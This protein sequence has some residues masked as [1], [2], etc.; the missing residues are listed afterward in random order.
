M[1][2][3]LRSLAGLLLFAVTLGLLGLAA[4]QIIWASKE[5]AG[6]GPPQRGGGERSFS[7]QVDRFARGPETP[8]ILSYGTVEAARSLELRALTGGRIVEL[9]ED[10]RDGGTVAEGELLFRIDPARATSALNIAT[11]ALEER[12]AELAEAEDRRDLTEDELDAA[13]QQRDLRAQAL[14]RQD[15]L[16]ARGVGT[17]QAA[18]DAQLSLSAAEQTLVRQ[19]QALAEAEAAIRTA[20]IAVDRAGIDLSDAERA[21]AET[22]VAAPFAGVLSDVTAILGRLVSANEKLGQLIDPTA[23]EVAFRVSNAQFARLLDDGGTLQ[24]LP[25]SVTLELDDIPFTLEGRIDRVGAEV[26]DGQTGRLIFAQIRQ[27]G[28]QILQPGDFLTVEIV[29]PELTDVSRIPADAATSDGRVLVLDDEDR[30]EEITLPILRRIGDELI[31]A[32][33]PEGR[34]YVRERL[35]Q[36]GAGIKVKP[37]TPPGEEGAQAP[38]APQSVVLDEARRARLI[39]FVEANTRMPADMRERILKQLEAEEV[40]VAVV[41]RLESR[42]GG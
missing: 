1:N 35:P 31:V 3:L 10:F 39:A 23:L 37:V 18:E 2:F 8:V 34:R 30:L 25:L 24:K 14:A 29:E 4:G 5:V 17:A 6:G 11:I 9:S 38:A 19:R 16:Q 21:L 40:P 36:L 28:Q 42:M 41:E 15:D 20:R 7:V 26:G 32:D 27:A 13:I 22:E 12:R 33:A